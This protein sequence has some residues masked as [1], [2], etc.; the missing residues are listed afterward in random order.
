MPGSNT[1]YSDPPTP[2]KWRRKTKPTKSVAASR[3]HAPDIEAAAQQ[4]QELTAAVAASL[5][6]DG[7]V[8]PRPPTAVAAVVPGGGNADANVDMTDQQARN[9]MPS[10]TAAHQAEVAA[11]VKVDVKVPPFALRDEATN[12]YFTT[13]DDIKRAA[14]E[15]SSEL[16]RGPRRGLCPA[17]EQRREFAMRK[18]RDFLLAVKAREACAASCKEREACAASCGISTGSGDC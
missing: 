14:N 15:W 12:E 7:R 8:A 10:G 9:C 16:D 5:P 18:E 1:N 11:A 3:T 2:G 4:L 13:V 6:G 17:A